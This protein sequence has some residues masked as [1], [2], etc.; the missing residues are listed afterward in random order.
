MLTFIKEKRKKKKKKEKKKNKLITPLAR[1]ID[2][3]ST[4]IF[5][6]RIETSHVRHQYTY[7]T[8]QK[9]ICKIFLDLDQEFV[10]FFGKHVTSFG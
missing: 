1:Y 2:W 8:V 6:F 4:M 5:V 3:L 7:N 9:K 10:R